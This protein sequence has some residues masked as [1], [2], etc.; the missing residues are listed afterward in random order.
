MTATGVN[1]DG[2]G[3]HS[4]MR[5]LSTESLGV[6]PTDTELTDRPAEIPAWDS[7][8][9]ELKPVLARQMEVYAG[10]LSHTDH[11]VGRLIDALKSLRSST[12]HWCSISSATMVRV[13]KEHRMEPSTSCWS[14]TKGVD[15][16]TTKFLK[17]HIDEF[18]TPAANN[19]YAV[20]W[21]HATCTPYQWTKQVASHFGGTRN[22]MVAH[23]P[24][25]I[26]TKGE[27]RSQFHHVTDIAPTVLEAAG[28]RAPT[29]VNGIQQMPLHGVSMR[30]CFDDADGRDATR[31]SI[32]RSSATRGIYHN[33][34]TAVTRHSIPWLATH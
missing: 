21:A 30:D 23:W 28:I 3:M 20:G 4:E 24:V 10:Y 32:S 11:H 26:A 19:H 25:G 18:G 2:G 13:Q 14:S 7:I 33:G 17:E 29:F 6:I 16:E 12:T 15:L 8:S 22:G 1:S 31:P 34:S 5:S 27:T 9:D